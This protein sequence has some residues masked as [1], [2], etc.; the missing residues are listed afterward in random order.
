MN[1]EKIPILVDSLLARSQEGELEWKTT[2]NP[3]TYL[4]TLKDSSI[5]ITKD[6][7]H[8][9]LV[10]RNEKGEVVRTVVIHT[11]TD[12]FYKKAAELFDLARKKATNSDDII[13]RIL[14]QLDPKSTLLAEI[15]NIR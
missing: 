13:D 4:L 9:E 12:S 2:S 14:K 11:G 8:I 10:F 1:G 5:A 6:I 7:T 3:L 15:D